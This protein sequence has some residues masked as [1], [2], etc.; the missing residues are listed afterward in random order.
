[1]RRSLW[2]QGTGCAWP[3]ARLKDHVDLINGYPFDSAGFNDV[4]GTHVIR[5]RDILGGT[6][7]TYFDGTV[8]PEVVVNAGDLIIGMDGD[9]NVVTWRGQSAALNQRLCVLRARAGLDQRF[10]AYF[11]GIPLKAIN[12]VT[13][14]TTVKHL[15][16]L[17][18]LDESIPLP[19]LQQQRA[20]ADYLDAETAR[21]D[22]LIEK[23]RRMVELVE[24]R[25]AIE[26]EGEIRGAVEKWGT[27]RL[28]Y[29][30]RGI[31]VGIVITPSSWYANEGVVALRGLNVKPGRLQLD[32][33]IRITDE[34]HRLH[35]KSELHY[36]DVVV[37]RT[38]Q[39]GAACG[40]RVVRRLQLYRPGHSAA[41]PSAAP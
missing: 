9:F 21:V 29:C 16:S 41:R 36:G 5:I 14:F 4:V 37:V 30:V 13:F 33:L 31:E 25:S 7:T 35:K 23:K 26:V 11:I 10:L 17:D 38:G 32:D 1:M 22:A 28:K 39:A 12:D 20:M 8:P 40:S 2:A 27:T 3:L 19:S 6:T 24:E 18:L 15:S 34:G